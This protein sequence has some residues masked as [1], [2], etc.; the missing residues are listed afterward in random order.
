VVDLKAIFRADFCASLS[1]AQ[2]DASDGAGLAKLSPSQQKFAFIRPSNLS[3]VAICVI[4]ES[5]S[6]LL[7]SAVKAVHRYKRDNLAARTER[8]ELMRHR[9]NSG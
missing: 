4:E 7:S 5:G 8:R 6:Y 3:I 2:D 1:S 9:H